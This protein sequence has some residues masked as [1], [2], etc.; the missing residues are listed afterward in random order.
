M[1]I[2]RRRKVCLGI[3][4]WR[5]ELRW[6]V[7]AVSRP[8]FL[9]FSDIGNSIACMYVRLDVLLISS[10]LNSCTCNVHADHSGHLPSTS[11]KYEVHF[12]YCARLAYG[13]GRALDAHARRYRLAFFSSSF[14]FCTPSISSDP[15]A[16]AP[17]A[18]SSSSA[19]SRESIRSTS[20]SNCA[21]VHS[22]A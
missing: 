20:S 10:R 7:G 22:T 2:G 1:R 11:T 12:V 13:P 19:S 5:V 15:S 9:P 17:S 3:W 14:H 16:S 6:W 8:L 4:M 18:S 21:R